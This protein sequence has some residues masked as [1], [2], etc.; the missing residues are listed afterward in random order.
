MEDSQDNL[1][2]L[3]DSPVEGRVHKQALGKGKDGKALAFQV[4]LGTERCQVLQHKDLL[5]A[6][7]GLRKDQHCLLVRW[8]TL[9]HQHMGLVTL[10]WLGHQHKDL[11]LVMQK[12]ELQ[13]EVGALEGHHSFLVV[14]KE[15]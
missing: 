13:W 11:A 14:L 2:V 6:A 3:E 1:A 9:V 5:A 4:G 7:A 12:Q 15:M 8:K 10:T